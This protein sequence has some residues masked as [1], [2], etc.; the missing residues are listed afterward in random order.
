M[1]RL[2][3]IAYLAPEGFVAQLQAEL[4]NVQ[5]VHERLIL[6]R[7]PLQA[8]H[9]AQ[10]IWL[11]PEI[12]K[13]ASIKDAARQLKAVQRNWWP[14][15]FHLHRR[16]EHIQ[17]ELPHLSAKPLAFPA[18]LPTA[19]LGSFALLDESTLLYSAAC[20]SPFPNGEPAFEEFKVGPPSRA[21]LKL[22]EALT[23]L[24]VRP[25]PGE[26]CVELGAS[27]GGWTWV[28]ARLG[29][30]V[31]AYDRA[32]LDPLVLAMPG[33]E[34][35]VGD[36]F[37]AKPEQ[38]PDGIDWLFSDIICYPGKLLEHVRLWL[39]S[40]KCRNFVCTLKFQGDDHYGVIAEFA[41]IPGARVFH[42]AHNKHELTFALIRSDGAL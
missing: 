15:A 35:R 19:P 33:V 6:A 27:P 3:A 30:S 21:Y 1:S 12:V 20:T 26:R 13:I 29:A 10:N 28:I 11:A 34:G 42:L 25:R 38:F 39:A 32:P 14:Y 18:D 31:V 4:Q 16:T 8:A 23:V 7:G 40:G 5:A 2:K 37:Q 9:W 36:A 24:G 41:A 22:F 17:N